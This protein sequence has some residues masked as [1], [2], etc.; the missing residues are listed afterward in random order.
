M[1]WDEIVNEGCSDRGMP[2]A[3][4]IITIIIVIVLLFLFVLIL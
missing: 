3:P 1:T 4:G 2:P